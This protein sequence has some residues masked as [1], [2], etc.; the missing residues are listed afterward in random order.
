MNPVEQYLKKLRKFLKNN[1]YYWKKDSFIQMCYQIW[2]GKE[3]IHYLRI[4]PE[5]SLLEGVERFRKMMDDCCCRANM[6]T[7][8]CFSVAYDVVTDVLD[9]LLEDQ[10]NE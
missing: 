9:F 7:K 2:A 8:M 5:L 6:E 1:L 4:H 10:E 3:I